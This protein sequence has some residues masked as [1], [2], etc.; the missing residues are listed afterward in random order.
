MEGEKSRGDRESHRLLPM[1]CFLKKEKK[2][3][4]EGVAMATQVMADRDWL[5]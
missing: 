4:W 1:G 5:C 3:I 2:I